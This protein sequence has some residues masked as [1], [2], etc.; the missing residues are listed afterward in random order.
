MR[1]GGCA[2]PEGVAPRPGTSFTPPGYPRS[3]KNGGHEPGVP[4]IGTLPKL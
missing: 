4:G 3:R 1:A 2:R